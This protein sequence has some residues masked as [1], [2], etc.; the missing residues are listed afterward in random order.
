MNADIRF[1][2]FIGVVGVV[3]I[4]VFFSIGMSIRESKTQSAINLCG[5]TLECYEKV[6]F[7]DN[8]Q[9]TPKGD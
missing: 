8:K 3:A 1:G 4:M 9:L 5:H 6:V 7:G 2:V